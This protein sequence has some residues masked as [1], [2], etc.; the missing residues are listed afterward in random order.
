MSVHE[1]ASGV[2]HLPLTPFAGVNAYLLGDVLV[3]AGSRHDAG[4]IVKAL[5]GRRVR[6]HALT[7]VHPDHQG[8]T[9]AV[10]T[11]LGLPLAV[12]AGEVA[13][14]EAGRAAGM[15]PPSLPGRIVRALSQGPGHPVSRTL[16]EGDEVGGFTVLHTPGHSPDH[17]AYWRE[18]DR[19]LIAGDALRNLSYATLRPR[20][21]LPYSGFNFDQDRVVESA[22]R[23]IALRPSLVAFGHGRPLSGDA[24]A[25]EADG[26]LAALPQPAR[27]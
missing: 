3:D 21:D 11:R 22:R 25:R 15:D 5:S 1:L 24:F 19:V 4:R 26:L 10:C 23:L 12:G 7:H 6:G 13:D 27:A 2:L 8:A 14:M 17:L 20:L 16:A 9:A 18:A